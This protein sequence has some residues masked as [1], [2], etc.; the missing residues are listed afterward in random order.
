MPIDK[1][2]R[3]ILAL[4]QSH[5][6]ISNHELAEQIGLSATP[7]AR[8]VKRLEDEGFIERYSAVVNPA[9]LGLD[10]TA[11]LSISMDK[12]TPERFDA[13]ETAIKAFPEVLECSIVT[14]QSADFMLKVIVK[15]MKHYETF[16][17][18]HLTKIPGVSGVHSSFVLRNIIHRAG[19]SVQ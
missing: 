9:M 17:L 13:F 6:R 3:K 1:I 19:V 14:G 16:L 4:L 8:R 12:H 7:C 15:D 2:D 18:Q 5:G 11:Y 10:L